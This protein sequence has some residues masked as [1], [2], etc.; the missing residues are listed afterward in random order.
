[1]GIGDGDG[2]GWDGMGM[3]RGWDGMGMGMDG[4]GWD[5][6]RVG[7]GTLFPEALRRVLVTRRV[8][9]R[10]RSR[11]LRRRM[12]AGCL[13]KAL[14]L[15]ATADAYGMPAGALRKS[16]QAASEEPGRLRDA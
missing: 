15:R 16:L 13:R 8:Y 4:M 9:L 2:T 11:R 3:G 5:G 1:M 14:R 10:A 6:M 12:P 7:M